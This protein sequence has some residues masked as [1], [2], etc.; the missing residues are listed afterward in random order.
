MPGA[1]GAKVKVVPPWT[2][3]DPAPRRVQPASAELRLRQA[4]AGES[5]HCIRMRTHWAGAPSSSGTDTRTPTAPG[6]R[7]CRTG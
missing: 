4:R 5:N 6:W 7:A 1:G 2:D 3:R